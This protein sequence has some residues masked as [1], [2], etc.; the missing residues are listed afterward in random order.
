MSDYAK[1]VVDKMNRQILFNM[2]LG[3]AIILFSFLFFAII[4]VGGSVAY[5]FAMQK[6]LGVSS[7]LELRQ[8]VD[9]R[10]LMLKAK[11]DK[12][13]LLMRVLSEFPDIKGHFLNPE[14]EALKEAGFKAL[15]RYASLFH[16]KMLGWISLKDSNYYVNGQF[17]EKYD[18]SNPAHAWFFET[19]A[20]EHRPRIRVDFDYL[21]RL[22]YDLYINYPV[23]SEGEPIGVLGSR[24]SLFEFLSDLNLPENSYVFGVDGI[25]VG[26]PAE[27]IAKEKKNLKEIFGPHGEEVHKKALSLRRKSSSEVLTLGRKHYLISGTGESDLFLVAVYE[28]DAKKTIKERASI[29]FLTLLFIMFLVFIVFNKLIIYILRPINRNMLLYIESSLLDELTRL[30]NRRFFNMKMKDEWSRAIRGRYPICFLMMDLDKFK[31]YNDTHGHSEGDVLLRETARIFDNCA[32]RV[33][34]LAARI[35]GEEFS[36]ILP[37]TELIGGQKLAESIRANVEKAGKATIS[38]GL[39]CKVPTLQDSM[40]DFIDTADQKLYEAKNTGRNKT[41]W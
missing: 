33:S 8:T 35:G 12:E 18:Y 5:Y 23:Y 22:I 31:A 37:N 21:N 19:L 7:M 17:M 30:P 20:N 32:G 2:P 10:K 13:I 15:E 1:N 3:K 25:V 16:S 26:A 41:C 6:V 4:A 36:I 29:V 9:T 27:R 38:I 34:D 14:D 39:V 11:L 40:Q 24:I 28:I